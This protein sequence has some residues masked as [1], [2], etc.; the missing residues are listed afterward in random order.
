MVVVTVYKKKTNEAINVVIECFIY[1]IWN[2]SSSNVY[3][4]KD[5]TCVP[6]L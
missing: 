2:V 5:D 4:K 1:Y 6:F 3:K